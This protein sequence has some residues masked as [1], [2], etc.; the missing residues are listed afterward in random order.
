MRILFS[1][2]ASLL[3]PMAT[4]QTAARPPASNLPQAP[5]PQIKTPQ[6]IALS[7]S[8][9]RSTPQAHLP[10]SAP[11]QPSESLTVFPHPDNTRWYIAGQAN[12]IFQAHPNFHSPYEE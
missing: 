7:S 5:A 3:I 11:P 4:A 1:L 12:S 8:P 6:I 9:A 2:F 10:T